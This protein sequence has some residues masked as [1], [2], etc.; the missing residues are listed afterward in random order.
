[1]F[2]DFAQIELVAPALT[3]VIESQFHWKCLRLAYKYVYGDDIYDVRLTV[4]DCLVHMQ[5]VDN[6][7]QYPPCQW[8][9]FDT[10]SCIGVSYLRIVEYVA[11]VGCKCTVN[12][13]QLV[14]FHHCFDDKRLHIQAT[15]SSHSALDS[16]HWDE[17]ETILE[18]YQQMILHQVDFAVAVD[19]DLAARRSTSDM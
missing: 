4:Y 12:R 10:N 11:V 19:L 5:G 16:S 7:P 2:P 6:G 18:Y 3:D 8:M 17:Q 1:M 15:T 14:T 13:L 9:T